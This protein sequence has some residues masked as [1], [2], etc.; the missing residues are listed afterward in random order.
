LGGE[1][2][3]FIKHIP[4]AFDLGNYGKVMNRYFAVC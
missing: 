2:S 3:L 1:Y 4:T